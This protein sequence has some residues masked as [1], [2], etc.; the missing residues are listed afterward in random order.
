MKRPTIA[1][2]TC[3]RRCKSSASQ[4]CMYSRQFSPLRS[5][6]LKIAAAATVKFAVA[7]AQNSAVYLSFRPLPWAPD[8]TAFANS[9]LSPIT[10][11]PTVVTSS[12]Y[13]SSAVE[14]F[15]WNNGTTSRR[16]GSS[17][18]VWTNS[19]WK[20]GCPLGSEETH[21]YMLTLVLWSSP[22]DT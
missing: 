12:S 21:R 11:P 20:R 2:T 1:S 4:S 8:A 13:S 7:K 16:H 22:R 18:T 15:R 5:R 19:I 3:A 10:A 6:R 9:L 14:P 17:R